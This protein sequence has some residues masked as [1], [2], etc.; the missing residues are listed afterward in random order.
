MVNINLISFNLNHSM[1]V[2]KLKT[3]SKQATMR[4]PYKADMGCN[5][6]IMPFNIFKNYFLAPQKIH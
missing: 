3:S 2:P 1:K 5:S 4:M 6:N